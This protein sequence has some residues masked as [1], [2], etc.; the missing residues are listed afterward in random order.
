VTGALLP[1]GATEGNGVGE[2][3]QHIAEPEPYIENEA[4]LL[5]RTLVETV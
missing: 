4:K 1:L 2:I 3:D 5:I